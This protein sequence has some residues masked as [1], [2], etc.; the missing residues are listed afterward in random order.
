MSDTPELKPVMPGE[1]QDLVD[2]A[3]RS[4][5]EM[6]RLQS[7]PEGV[8]TAMGR[9]ATPG[10]VEFLRSM[11]ATALTGTDPAPPVKRDPSKGMAEN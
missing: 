1:L 9:S 11:G 5:T 7:D 6:A 2:R 3:R 4:P 10:A 8:L